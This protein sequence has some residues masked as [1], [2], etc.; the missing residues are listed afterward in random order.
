VLNPADGWVYVADTGNK[1]IIKMD[2]ISGVVGP[3][4]EG[5]EDIVT[6]VSVDNVTVVDFVPNDGTLVAPSGIEVKGDL[7]YVSDNATSRFLA[8]DREGKLVRALDTGWPPGS[9]AGFTFGPDG[10]IW[11]VDLV[12]SVFRIDPL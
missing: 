11:F 5:L 6:R 2:P 10:K 4:F 12:G 7:V 1:R 3:A 8:F 9:L